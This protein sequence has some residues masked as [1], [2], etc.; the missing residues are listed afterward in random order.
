MQDE[1]FKQYVEATQAMITQTNRS[2]EQIR[3][4]LRTISEVER[5]NL[6]MA[7]GA[8]DM[9]YL[10]IRVLTELHA[11]FRTMLIRFSQEPATNPA[12]QENRDLLLEMLAE[13]QRAAGERPSLKPVPPANA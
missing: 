8:Y 6:K 12:A 9:S 4:A 13:M 7:A 10:V 11:D 3:D 1:Q 2:L 5:N